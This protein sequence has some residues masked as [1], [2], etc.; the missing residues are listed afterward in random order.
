MSNLVDFSDDT[1]DVEKPNVVVAQ[2]IEAK[3][4]V[5]DTRYESKANLLTHV[6]GSAWKINLY[7][8]ILT[9]DMAPSGFSIGR[10]PVYQ[11]YRLIKEYELRV[12]G[13]LN[14]S[15]DAETKEL[16]LVGS[17]VMYPGLIPNIG[18]MFIADIG[19]GREGVFKITNSEQRTIFKDTCYAIEYMLIDHLKDEYFNILETKVVDRLVFR[20]D[21][22]EYGQ[23][24]LI[25]QN[26][27]DQIRLLERHYEEI[28]AV[29]FKSFFSKEFNTLLI[30]GQEYPI[31]DHFLVKALLTFFN[32]WDTPEIRYVRLL[33][34]QDD[35]NMACTNFW[36]LI[37][38]G[39]RHLLNYT[40]NQYG[41]VSSKQFDRQ[42]MLE[43]LYFSKIPFVLYPRDPVQDVDW[44]RTAKTK[45]FESFN[46]RHVPGRTNLPGTT[47]IYN[48]GDD[49]DDFNV[50]LRATYVANRDGQPAPEVPPPV[51][52]EW[53]FDDIPGDIDYLTNELP[54]IHLVTIDNYYVLSSNFYRHQTPPAPPGYSKL[55]V[56]VC[57]ML[58]RKPVTLE[59]LLI[60]C[61]NYHSWGA[62]ERYYYLPLILM[63]IKYS[64][65]S[66]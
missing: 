37:A 22:L 11:Q 18:D 35:N 20:K 15:Q 54:D 45:V 61:E 38:T 36:D 23:K 57:Q 26:E 8:Q 34:V 40:F 41:I 5:V 48:D 28:V 53:N 52:I 39:D 58:G 47:P 4:T 21:F 59:M 2:P 46:I 17:G 42:P 16:T 44:E 65:R 6:E 56:L 29:Y 64:I 66:I 12:T 10:H 13:P 30:P 49:A 9:R 19:D 3:T 7:T 51:I 33:N 63:L 32:T 27:S 60:L 62:V 50:D 25:H 31:Y 1:E 14:T 55:E 24:P 43:G